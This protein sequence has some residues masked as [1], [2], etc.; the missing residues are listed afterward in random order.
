MKFSYRGHEHV[1]ATHVNIFRVMRTEH[2]YNYNVSKSLHCYKIVIILFKIQGLSNKI[3]KS[4]K[5]RAILSLD[6]SNCCL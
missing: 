1:S 2:Q 4:I 6:A 3:S 5:Y